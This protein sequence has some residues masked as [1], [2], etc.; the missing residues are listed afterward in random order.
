MA[1]IRDILV[2]KDREIL[3]IGPRETS[4]DAALLMNRK[5]V[6]SLLVME[7][8]AVVGIVT[9]RDLLQRVLAERRDPAATSVGEVMTAEVLCCQPHTTIEEARSVMK[10]R[11]IRHLPVVDH[12][13][14]LHG[15]ISIGDLN[16]YEAQSQEMTIHVMTEYIHGRT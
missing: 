2:H 8:E 3:S 5:K 10:N 4:L 15:L 1:T 12:D 11:R 14:R 16:A 9:E 7:E 13:G 6:G